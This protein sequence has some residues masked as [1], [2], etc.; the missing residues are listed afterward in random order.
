MLAGEPGIGKTRTAQELAD[1]AARHDT[2]VL[3]GRCPEEP[4]APPYWPGCK[5]SAAMPS[6]PTTRRYE[7]HSESRPATSPT[8]M[9]ARASAPRRPPAR[10]SADAV[11]ARFQLFDAIA[12]FWRNA[13]RQTVLLVLDDLHRADMSSLRLLD[14]SSR[15]KGVPA[16]ILGTYR[17]S[18]ITREHPLSDTLAELAR[19]V[20]FQRLRLT[21]LRRRR[22]PS[23]S[24]RWPSQPPRTWP[25][26]L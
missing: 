9:P 13:A 2:L 12:E 21:G 7:R 10:P 20:S 11:E 16:L 1:D 15:G 22:P 26:A 4:G 23:F 5:L 8:S 18:E 3:W 14:S 25:R 17:D 6:A 24:R 19:H